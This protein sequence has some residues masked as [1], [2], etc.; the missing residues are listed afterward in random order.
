MNAKKLMK[1]EKG[2]RRWASDEFFL[3]HQGV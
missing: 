2:N 3:T 1:M